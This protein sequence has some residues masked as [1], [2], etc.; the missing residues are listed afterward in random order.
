[1]WGCDVERDGS[2]LGVGWTTF[3]VGCST[4]NLFTAQILGGRGV[5]FYRS[6]CYLRT[7]HHDEMAHSVYIFVNIRGGMRGR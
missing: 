3:D 7:P 4:I 6:G 5:G 1:M 2:S